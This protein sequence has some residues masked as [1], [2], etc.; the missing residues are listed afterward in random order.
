MMVAVRG[1]EKKLD[2]K[3]PMTTSA[4][5][6]RNR[7][8]MSTTELVWVGGKGRGGEERKKGEERG[9]GRGGEGSGGRRG[10]EGKPPR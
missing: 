8:S 3:N 9:E 10:I 1:R 6:Q 2:R 4:W 5:P 7:H